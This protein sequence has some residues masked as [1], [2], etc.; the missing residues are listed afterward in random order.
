MRLWNRK[1]DQRV[2]KSPSL[3]LILSHMNPVRALTPYLSKIHFNIILPSIFSVFK[4]KAKKHQ[5]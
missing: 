5:N 4:E 1:A 3:E 2:R